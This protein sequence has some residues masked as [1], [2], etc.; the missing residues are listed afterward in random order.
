MALCNFANGESIKLESSGL[1]HTHQCNPKYWGHETAVA[2]LCHLKLSFPPF[3]T[4][5]LPNLHVR[6][7]R[8][9]PGVWKDLHGPPRAMLAQG[10]TYDQAKIRVNTCRFFTCVYAQN[11]VFILLQ[12]FHDPSPR[13]PCEPPPRRSPSTPS[14]TPSLCSTS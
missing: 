10:F 9:T 1:Q 3:L 5:G 14:E 11:Y 8:T 6:P 13:V 12:A 2:L 7:P 4:K